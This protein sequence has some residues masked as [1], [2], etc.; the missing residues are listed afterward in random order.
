MLI[1]AAIAACLSNGLCLDTINNHVV[2]GSCTDSTWNSVDCPHFCNGP[3]QGNRLGM[4][5]QCNGQDKWWTCKEDV[6]DCSSK[7]EVAQGQ[8]SD[9]RTSD[10]NN[11]VYANAQ[12]GDSNASSGT[13][14]AL[15][16]GLG[17]G[18]GVGLPLLIAL[19]ASLFFLRRSRRELA[20]AKKEIASQASM[21]PSST[22]IYAKIPDYPTE[23]STTR[24]PG[25]LSPQQT[26]SGP[27]TVPPYASYGSDSITRPPENVTSPQELESRQNT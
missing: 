5:R 2:R 13:G 21:P 11:V 27:C 14:A 16:A 15:Q 23:L 26:Y 20:D 9:K 22:P 6:T 17:A 8:I 3:T 1:R 18:L 19:L 12:Q 25:E 24:P 4:L 10:V 7:F